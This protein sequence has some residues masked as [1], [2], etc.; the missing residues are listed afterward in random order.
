VELFDTMSASYDRAITVFSPDGRLQQVEYAMKAVERG[1]AVVGVRTP[2]AVIIGVE[3]RSAAKL[4]DPRTMKKVVQLDENITLAFAGLN[5]DAR[6]LIDKAR[7]ECQSHKLTFEDAASVEY[8]ARYVSGV[9]QK[10]T[11]SGGRRP[12]GITTLIGGFDVDGKPQLWRTRPA[13]TH[14]SWRACATGRQGNTLRQFLVKH[15]KSP[16][17]DDSHDSEMTADQGIDL[18]I[19]ALLEVVENGAAN[20]EVTVIRKGESGASL[21]DTETIEAIIKRVEAEKEAEAA[22]KKKTEGY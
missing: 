2:D 14:S 22:K 6:I 12:F 4:Q 13:G 18:T 17:V 19:K 5:A 9:Q 20:I 11:R 3:V 1:A 8:V 10:Y 16:E 7:I 21:L 15:Y